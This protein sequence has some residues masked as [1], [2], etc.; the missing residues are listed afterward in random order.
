MNVGLLEGQIPAIALTSKKDVETAIKWLNATRY[1]DKAKET[2]R[3]WCLV[4]LY[5][6]NRRKE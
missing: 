3:T 1:K 6:I 4:K 2:E 5:L